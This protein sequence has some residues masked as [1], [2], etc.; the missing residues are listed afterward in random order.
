MAWR[1]VGRFGRRIVVIVK[2][3]RSRLAASASAKGAEC[4]SLGQ[5]PRLRSFEIS[6]SAEGA[7]YGVEPRTRKIISPFQGEKDSWRW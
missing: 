6:R 7:E 5:R 2:D 3:K 4:E 1:R